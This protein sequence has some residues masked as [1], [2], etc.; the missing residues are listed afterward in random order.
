MCGTIGE[1]GLGGIDAQSV[2]VSAANAGRVYKI[3]KNQTRMHFNYQ[4]CSEEI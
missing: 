2:Y 4:R 1:Q 3:I